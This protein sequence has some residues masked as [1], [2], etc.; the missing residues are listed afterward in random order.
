M[1]RDQT[2][3]RHHIQTSFFSAQEANELVQLRLGLQIA[4]AGFRVMV[5]ADE[6]HILGETRVGLFKRHIE[7]SIPPVAQVAVHRIS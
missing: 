6:R 3:S 1:W 5:H 4:E 2:I 7:Y